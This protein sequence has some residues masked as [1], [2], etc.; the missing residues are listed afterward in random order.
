MAQTYLKKINK[1]AA[2]ECRNR[3]KVRLMIL[4]IT[5]AAAL[6]EASEFTVKNYDSDY[7]NWIFPNYDNFF[8]LFLMFVAAAFGAFAVYGVF[9]D[10]TNKQTADVQLS[11]PMSAK[12]RFH[13]KLLAVAKLHLIPLACA[14][15]FVLIIQD[16][17]YNT[18]GSSFR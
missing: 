10:L 12:E 18:C 6:F 11:L 3:R 9:S 1:A 2:A 5:V 8:G 16:T 4:I 14:S 7:I 17:L 13:S 15:L